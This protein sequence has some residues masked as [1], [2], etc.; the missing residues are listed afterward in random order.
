MKHAAILVLGLLLLIGGLTVVTNFRG[1]ADWLG[2]YGRRSNEAHPMR[3]H[4]VA[5]ARGARI[6][7]AVPTVMGI[8]L[9]VLTLLAK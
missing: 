6:W 9:V 7:G 1:A 5:T 8:L 2:E 4:G 3:S